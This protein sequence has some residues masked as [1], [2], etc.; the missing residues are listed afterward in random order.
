MR[1]VEATELERIGP[2]LAPGRHGSQSPAGAGWAGIPRGDFHVSCKGQGLGEGETCV[3]RGSSVNL[4]S[5]S[6]NGGNNLIFVV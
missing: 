5:P 2:K 6:V 3:A 4:T 1:R